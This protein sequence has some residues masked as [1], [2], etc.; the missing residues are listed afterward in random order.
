MGFSTEDIES[1][2]RK[3][4]ES[5]ESIAAS[6]NLLL[7]GNYPQTEK[8]LKVYRRL[9]KHN[10]KDETDFMIKLREDIEKK[11][12]LSTKS[13]LESKTSG[14]GLE[15]LFTT[16]IHLHCIPETE[17]DAKLLTINSGTPD[18]PQLGIDLKKSSGKKGFTVSTSSTEDSAVRAM[19]KRLTGPNHDYLIFR[20][21]GEEPEVTC[22]VLFLQKN[23]VRDKNAFSRFKQAVIY[24]NRQENPHDYEKFL[25][26]YA[27]FLILVRTNIT[28]LRFIDSVFLS[29]FGPMLSEKNQETGKKSVWDLKQKA[30]YNL[31][32]AEEIDKSLRA[33]L[34]LYATC[35]HAKSAQF[36]VDQFAFGQLESWPWM[37]ELIHENVSR[38]VPGYPKFVLHKDN[39]SFEQQYFEW[40]KHFI[41]LY[42]Q[43]ELSI[44]QKKHRELI[45]LILREEGD[46]GDQ[47]AN[48]STKSFE[49]TLSMSID[50]D[51]EEETS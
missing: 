5:L 43:R 33:E 8:L 27:T 12:P 19:Q 21:D 16:L 48:L 1:I 35:P 20:F 39:G 46:T 36:Y 40:T 44:D 17:Y 18:L 15:V 24:V 10:Q 13:F 49:L 25:T 31:A 42:I 37:T 30:K 32:E 11:I 23:Q 34:E 22:R 47:A 2:R 6:M 4:K 51:P 26:Q 41:D 38:I 28:I 45:E 29:S 3:L 14:E 9:V 50:N 7:K